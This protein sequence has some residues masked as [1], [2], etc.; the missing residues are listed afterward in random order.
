MCK[1]KDLAWL[2]ALSLMNMKVRKCPF[3]TLKVGHF[4]KYL[5]HEIDTESQFV[6]AN[7]QVRWGCGEW[8]VNTYLI[9]E[10]L[11][12]GRS[13]V[14]WLVLHRVENND[15]L[16]QHKAWDLTLEER[17]K[18]ETHFLA[19]VLSGSLPCNQFCMENNVKAG[20]K[21][22]SLGTRCCSRRFVGT[23]SLVFTTP[24]KEGAASVSHRWGNG[25]RKIKGLSQL[26]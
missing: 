12:R 26:T 8:R 21:E 11:L 9:S 18:E 16:E 6:W 23:H 24:C 4:F 7:S 14:R 3:L 15:L 22:S 13:A 5:S 20:C 25:D 17:G 10:E 19:V 1:E 2:K